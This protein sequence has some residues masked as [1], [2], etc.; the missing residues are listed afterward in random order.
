[1]TDTIEIGTPQYGKKP[2]KN[3]WKIKDGD[4][5]YRILP[6][7]GKL[8]AQGVWAVFDSIHWGFKGTKFSRPFKCIQRK[9]KNK[10]VIVQCPECDKIAEYQLQLKQA[11]DEKKAEGFSEE[12][13]KEFVKP[14]SDWLYNHNL[15]KKWYV[16]AVSQDGQ[17]GRLAMPH[18]MYQALQQ[19]I[20][21]LRNEDGIEPIGADGGVWFVLNRTGKFN[22]TAFAVDVVMTTEDLG[23]GRKA[24][25]IK[26]APL[27][28]E[29]KSRLKAEA[30]D[31]SDN[32]RVLTYDEIKRVVESSYD[33][34]EVDHVFSSPDTSGNDGSGPGEDEPENGAVATSNALS[35]SAPK[36]AGPSEAEIEARIRAEVQ[37]RMKTGSSTVGGASKMSDEDF[38][39]A[40]KFDK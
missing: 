17:I 25:V 1:M 9:N 18:K 39:S 29:L 21:K 22:Q 31:L 3:N 37:A 35:R 14:L 36:S 20:D 27:T 2:T 8:A 19:K 13:I 23:G 6:P 38:I 30:F 33:P 15:D 11:Q 7:L 32:S 28:D 12:K 24:K 16:N 26:P 34:E 4:N 40:F 5:I 10:M